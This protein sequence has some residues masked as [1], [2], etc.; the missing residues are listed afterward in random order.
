MRR[1]SKKRREM[2]KTLLY[3]LDLFNEIQFRDNV[4]QTLRYIE[5]EIDALV[6]KL[7]RMY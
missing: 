7:K 1:D 5:D 2:K 4:E 6:E 3:F